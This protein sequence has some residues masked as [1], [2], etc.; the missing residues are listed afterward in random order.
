MLIRLCRD[1][2]RPIDAAVVEERDIP[3]ALREGRAFAYV[4]PNEWRRP[5]APGDG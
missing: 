3:D 1:C 4:Q 5:G 2:A